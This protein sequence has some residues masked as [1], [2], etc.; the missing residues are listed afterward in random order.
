[1]VLFIKNSNALTAAINLR[2]NQYYFL[3][4]KEEQIGFSGW[5][6]SMPIFLKLW[7]QYFILT[8]L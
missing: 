8:L 6:V 4:W 3:E 1:M 5:I 7:Y 2:Q